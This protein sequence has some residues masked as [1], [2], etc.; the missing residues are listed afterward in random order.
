[1]VA[2]GSLSEK[3]SANR[4]LPVG[5]SMI[6]YLY[7]YLLHTILKTYWRR[8]QKKRVIIKRKSVIQLRQL[9]FVL[10]SFII[11]LFSF[12]LCGVVCIAI[13]ISQETLFCYKFF[14]VIPSFLSLQ[15]LSFDPDIR[16]FFN[17]NLE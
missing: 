12:E 9:H 2:G 7:M 10:V 5:L 15:F 4:S 16:K 1:M 14:A 3:M 6:F 8:G 11:R 13:S 17:F